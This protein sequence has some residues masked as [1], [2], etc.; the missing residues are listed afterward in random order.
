MELTELTQSLLITSSLSLPFLFTVY[1]HHLQGFSRVT[2]FI[3]LYSTILIFPFVKFMNIMH[4][5]HMFIPFI[6]FIFILVF[7]RCPEFMDT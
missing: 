3:I 2:D 7:L 6:I 4:I 1:Q 5:A